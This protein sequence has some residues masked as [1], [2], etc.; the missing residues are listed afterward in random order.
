MT[1]GM[2]TK[3]YNNLLPSRVMFR[4]MTMVTDLEEL[5]YYNTDRVRLS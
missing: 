1:I 4:F 5:V 2:L 3:F